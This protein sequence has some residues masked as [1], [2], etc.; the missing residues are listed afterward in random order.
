MEM[1]I[2]ARKAKTLKTLLS[3]ARPILLDE[4]PLPTGLRVALL[5]PHP[6]DFDAIAVTLR[7]FRDAGNGISVA[8]LSGGASGV[9]D[10]YCEPPSDD[11]KVELRRLEQ[12]ASC[13]M[14]GLPDDALEF[15]PLSEDV[16]GEPDNTP[17][18]AEILVNHLARIHPDIVFLPH[19]N[20]QKPGHRNVYALVQQAAARHPSPLV[21]F[22]NR[23]PKT[24]SC[25][26]DAFTRYGEED[27]RWKAQLLRCHDSQQQRNLNT[28]GH[29]FDERILEHD[30]KNAAECGGATYAEAFEIQTL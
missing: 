3:L 2:A 26:L 5:G 12:R 14:F 27:A 21:A 1:D 16:D 4:C 25:R 7:H 28:R 6:D 15:L 22:L 18:N 24:V 20:D 19:G 9:E 10:G 23:D 17:A 13:R 11:R 29:G 8:V 30:R